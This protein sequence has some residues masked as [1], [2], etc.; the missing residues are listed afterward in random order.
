MV[1]EQTYSLEAETP[2]CF[3][4]HQQEANGI[5]MCRFL[6]AFSLNAVSEHRE[7]EKKEERK[8]NE[9]KRKHKKKNKTNRTK[10]R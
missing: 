1:E 8:K 3:H 9:G 6:R 10:V 4:L 2:F 7:K 5:K